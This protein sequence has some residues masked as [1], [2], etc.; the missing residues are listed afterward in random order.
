VLVMPRER[1]ADIRALAE[2]MLKRTDGT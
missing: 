2:A 1:S